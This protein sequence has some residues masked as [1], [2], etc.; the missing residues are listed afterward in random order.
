MRKLSLEDVNL[1]FRTGNPNFGRSIFEAGANGYIGISDKE[2]CY[3]CIP[4]DGENKDFR[5]SFSSVTLFARKRKGK[6][7]L[8]FCW[9]GD[10]NDV[11]DIFISTALAEFFPEE[12]RKR[13][14][15]EP[16][17][18]ANRLREVFG[19]S[20]VKDEVAEKIAELYVYYQFIENNIQVNFGGFS[21]KSSIDI[22]GSKFDIEVKSTTR[23]HD[24]NFHTTPEQLRINADH[25]LYLTLCRLE[26]TENP[27]L[28]WSIQ[29]LFDLLSAKGISE[30]KGL[31]KNT[32]DRERLYKITDT[33]VIK[34]DSDFPCPELP[35]NRKG[36]RL[37]SYEL[38]ILPN[39]LNAISLEE[40]IQKYRLIS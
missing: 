6:Y 22:E 14:F 24:W 27:E 13:F 17:I 16:E 29:K 26:S 7:E 35:P 25:P 18:F 37:V 9:E 4:L 20:D 2:K 23:H 8:I 40:F 5:E 39:E 32:S 15:H 28:G 31:P 3:F 21:E 38:Q 30:I 10:R 11:P 36:A 34:I 19:N 12:K 1:F 33:K